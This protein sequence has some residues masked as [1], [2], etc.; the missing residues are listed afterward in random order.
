MIA[1]VL[2]IMIVT[3]IPD[4]PTGKG[5][6][7]RDPNL[8]GL[9]MEKE[10][11]LF[12]TWKRKKKKKMAGTNWTLGLQFLFPAGFRFQSLCLGLWECSRRFSLVFYLR[13]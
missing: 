11:R 5:R 1:V 2:V 7:V 10:M 9:S 6:V 4:I 13:P 3:L 12:L 8:Y